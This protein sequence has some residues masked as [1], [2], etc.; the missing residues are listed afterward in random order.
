[1]TD[2]VGAARAPEDPHNLCLS[3]A[4][5]PIMKFPTRVPALT[6]SYRNQHFL[7]VTSWNPGKKGHPVGWPTIKTMTRSPG[8][9]TKRKSSKP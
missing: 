2:I 1:M 3:E 9:V 7:P 4:L 6:K 8:F 5:A